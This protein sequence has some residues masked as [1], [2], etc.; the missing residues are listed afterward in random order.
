MSQPVDSDLTVGVRKWFGGL[1]DRYRA[2][3]LS[4][5]FRENTNDVMAPV[6]CR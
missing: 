4:S 5:Q 6:M 3:G 2:E 1:L